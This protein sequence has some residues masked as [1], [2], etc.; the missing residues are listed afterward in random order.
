MAS[1]PWLSLIERGD[2]TVEK[3]ADLLALARVLKVEPGKLVGGVEL[4]PNGGSPLDPPRG[5]FAVRRALFSAPP[6]D[7]PPPAAE[8]RVG[9]ERAMRLRQDGRYEAVGIVLPELLMAGRAAVVQDAP[10]VWW[11]LAVAYQVVASL[12]HMVGEGD[13]ALLAADRAVAAAERS[14]DGQLAAAS[15]RWLAFALLGLGLLD[16]TGAVCSD[17]A[18]VIAPTDKTPVEGWSLWGSLQLTAA[19]AA[20]R[21][22]NG[23]EAWRLLRDARTAAERV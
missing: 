2:R 18:D 10:D 13:L 3:I 9:V 11:P 6:D 23:V 22:G 12:A 14:G 15:V 4:P 1:V 20:V 19:V 21:G 5:I 16:E 17:A 8:L 7:E